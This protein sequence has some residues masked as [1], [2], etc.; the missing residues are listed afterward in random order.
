MSVENK[1]IRIA[2][3]ADILE[4]NFDGVTHTLYHIVRHAPRD[5]FDFV[6]VTPHPPKKE[7]NFPFS[8]IISPG[9]KLPLYKEYM[10]ALPFLRKSIERKLDRFDPHIIHFTTPSLLG[11][12]ALRY[13]KKKNIPVITT[14]HSHFPS[15][16]EYYFRYIPFAY[17]IIFPLIKKPLWLYPQCDLTLAPSMEMKEFLMENDVEESKI[18]FWKRGVDRNKFHQR[19][20]REE[21]KKEHG[22]TEEKTVLFVSRLVKEKEVF[23]L[24][25]VYRLFQERNLKVRFVVVGQGPAGQK[26]KEKM[27]NAVFLG[28][29]TGQNL[30]EAFAS[31]DIF[32]FPSIT[33]TFGNVVLEALSSG[34]PVVTAQAGGPKD[35]VQDG[36]T[37]Y[38]VTPKSV[39]E[40]YEKI[41]FLLRDGEEYKKFRAHAI[42]YAETQT[43]ANVCEELYKIYEEYGSVREAKQ[44]S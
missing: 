5:R 1:K 38:H 35:I 3:F 23:T 25:K 39:E 15:Y 6:F 20:R 14:Y 7:T 4:E 17:N 18:R 8:V 42:S 22:I 19:F 36:I 26:L 37:G 11:V 16:I 24:A 13:G 32:M 30:S 40:F 2:F 34:L 41:S 27:P 31:C 12:Y 9:I 33:E 10:F 28:K 43:W 44:L 21:W 29:Q